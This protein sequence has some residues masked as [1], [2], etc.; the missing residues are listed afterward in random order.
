MVKRATFGDIFRIFRI[1]QNKEVE[2][3]IAHVTDDRRMKKRLLEVLFCGRYDIG[4]S[5]N[6]DAS[7]GR[8]HFGIRPE[9][10]N[11]TGKGGRKSA[12]KRNEE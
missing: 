2:I 9:L 3:A 10:L 7:I 12:R 4:Q 6:R 5:R 1:K 11:E 8:P